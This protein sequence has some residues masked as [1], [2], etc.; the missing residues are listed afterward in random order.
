MRD[1]VPARWRAVRAQPCTDLASVLQWEGLMM[2]NTHRENCEAINNYER[3]F[4]SSTELF[5]NLC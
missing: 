4:V 1:K 2:V 5:L 3:G